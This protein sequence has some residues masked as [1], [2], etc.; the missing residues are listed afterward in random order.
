MEDL[1]IKKNNEKY[2]VV[3]VIPT[4][5]ESTRFSGKPLI[6][7][8]GKTMIRRVID[9][10]RMTQLID[11]IVVA[12]DDIRIKENVENYDCAVEM[13]S[14]DHQSGTER[15]GEI[16]SKYD[17][18][19][20]VNVQGD[21][22]FISPQVIDNTIK[23]LLNNPKFSVTTTA[24]N[25]QNIDEWKN[26]NRVKVVLNDHNEAMYFTR[27]N[28]P[29]PRNKWKNYP[30]NTYK[31]L[32]LYCYRKEAIVDFI[33]LHPAELERTESLEQLRFLV[34]GFKIGVHITDEESPSVD[35]KDDLEIIKKWAKKKRLKIK[36]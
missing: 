27:A 29:Y 4:R 21:E 17:A 31:H 8:L 13:T 34:N 22:P 7:I 23:L 1:H 24:I 5:Y 25:F 26:P 9:R 15:I 36:D 6:E 32:G 3:G 18:K 30:P 28:I 2:N 12:T 35:T 14:K 20:Y 10:V 33:K 19:F 16:L 11:K